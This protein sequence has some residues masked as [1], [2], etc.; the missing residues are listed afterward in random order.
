MYEGKEGAGAKGAKRGRKLGRIVVRVDAATLEMRDMMRDEDGF[1]LS[2][3][4]R[5]CI[6]REFA[7]RGLV[8]PHDAR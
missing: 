6:E 5:G 1:N 4:V 7:G 8:L 2:E 3:V